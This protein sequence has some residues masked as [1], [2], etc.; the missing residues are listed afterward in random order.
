MFKHG[1]M[2]L[3]LASSFAFVAPAEAKLFKWVDENGTTHYGEVIPPEYANRDSSTISSKGKVTKRSEKFDPEL[4]HAKQVEKER[5]QAEAEAT[6]EQKR[7]DT[8]LLNTYS[9]EGEID[10]ALSRSLR[11]LEARVGS[12]NSMVTSAQ[13]SL[14]SRHKEADE[15]T[16]AGK[17]IPQSLHDEITDAESRLERLKKD[18]AH[19]EKEVADV[20]ARYEEDKIRYRELKGVSNKK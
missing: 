18:F 10:L 2:L 15:R 5:K 12:L 6:A 17:K 1:L 8:A 16:K 20:K 13:E 4:E 3:A 11:L 7:R 9:N 14:D 19:S